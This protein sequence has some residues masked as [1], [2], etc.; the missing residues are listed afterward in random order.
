MTSAWP[1]GAM[2]SSSN[3][4][5]K[6]RSPRGPSATPRKAASSSPVPIPLIVPSQWVVH[7]APLEDWPSNSAASKG[8][9][10]PPPTAK[11]TC[12]ANQALLV[13]R[14]TDS[15]GDG[16]NGADISVVKDGSVVA[17]DTYK[18]GP[19]RSTTTAWRRAATP[20]RLRVE[21]GGKRSRGR[22][23]SRCPICLLEL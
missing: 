8:K 18:T 16:W 7:S 12:P 6:T 1:K 9:V 19:T 17:A 3:L 11:F 13:L 14:L 5:A 10:T 2:R 23:S 4:Q 20:S 22:L 15:W 21:S